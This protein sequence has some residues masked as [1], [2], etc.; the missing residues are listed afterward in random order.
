MV[1]RVGSA[2]HGVGCVL[3]RVRVG[4]VEVSVS[5]F[6]FRAMGFLGAFG[7]ENGVQ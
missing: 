7:A 4:S 2:G 3:V 6:A 5:S 1:G